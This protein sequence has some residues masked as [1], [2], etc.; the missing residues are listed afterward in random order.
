MF[1]KYQREATHIEHNERRIVRRA[2]E[3]LFI[4]CLFLNCCAVFSANLSGAAVV[5]LTATRSTGPVKENTDFSY[6]FPGFDK[7]A[8][9]VGDESLGELNIVT[10]DKSGLLW[11]GTDVTGLVRY[12]GY[13]WRSYRHIQG[14]NKSLGSN[15]VLAL[16]VAQDGLIWVGTSQ[17]VSAFDPD[18]EQSVNYVHDDANPDSLVGDRVNRILGDTNGNIWLGVFGKGLDYLAKGSTTIRHFHHDPA[19]PTSLANDFVG[20]LLIDRQ[21]RFWVGTRDGLQRLLPDGTGFERVASRSGD[22]NSLAGKS[23][24]SLYEALDGKIWIGT[25]TGLAWMDPATFELHFIGRDNAPG[26]RL[27]NEFI[28]KIIQPLPDEIW[29]ATNGG[30][31]DVLA[32]DDGRVLQ[33]WQKDSSLDGNLEHE[34]VL[35]MAR[36]NEGNVWVSGMQEFLQRYNL[37]QRF[38]Y[39]IRH[40][41]ERINGLSAKSATSVLELPDGR[42]LVGTDGN[43]IDILDRQ[44]G[45]VGGYRPDGRPGSLPKGL[46]YSLARSSDGT[47]WAGTYT[48]VW[49]LPPGQA[50]WNAYTDKGI[51]K[52]GIVQQFYIDSDDSVW[53]STLTGLL[54]WTKKANRFEPVL[55]DS[56]KPLELPASASIRDREGNLWVGMNMGLGVIEPGHT[57]VRMVTK[58]EQ[59]NELCSQRVN[60]FLIDHEGHLLII[61]LAGVDKLLKWDGKTATIE[62]V[63]PGGKCNGAV[64]MSMAEDRQGR[65]WSENFVSS[66]DHAAVVLENTG[67]QTGMAN[68]EALA[69]TRDGLLLMGRQNGLLIVDPD[70][71]RWQDD[72]PQVVVTDLRIDGQKSPISHLSPSIKL[73]PDQRNFTLDFVALN[74]AGNKLNSY[75]YQLEGFS[76]DWS[77]TDSH[78]RFVVF[79]NLWPGQYRLHV[80]SMNEAGV[81]DDKDGLSIPVTVLPAFWQ[82]VWFAVLMV[83]F[84]IAFVAWLVHM[85]TVQL[86]R[87]QVELESIVAKRT[88]QLKESNEALVIAKETAERATNSKSEFLANMSHEIRTPMNAIIGMANL[89]LRTELSERQRDY[90]QKVQ[91]S[92]KH[93]LRIINDVLDLS[94][95]EAGKLELENN[96]FNLEQMLN[97]AMTLTI[98]RASDKGLQLLIDVAGNVPQQLMGDETRLSQMLVNY[99]S[100]AIK[101]TDKG[102][103]TLVVRLKEKT[104]EGVLVYFAVKDTGIGLNDDQQKRLFQQFQQANSSTTRL[105]GGTGLGLALVKTLAGQMQG[106]VGV[107]S[108]VGQGSTF[109][110]TVQLGVVE[111]SEPTARPFVDARHSEAQAPRQDLAGGRVLL[112]EDNLLNQQVA[113]ELMSDAGLIVTVASDGE[114]AQRLARENE[115]ELILM[116]M[117]MPVMD[118][119]EATRRIRADPQ[120]RGT[121]VIAMTANSLQVDRQHC[122]DAGMVDF[123]TK[124]IDPAE[125]FE[126]LRKWVQ[127]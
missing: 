44:R 67:F 4:F 112:V 91:Q 22:P 125:L 120:Y 34:I 76:K 25:K 55:L 54:R 49:A 47:L 121:P 48:G 100:N 92:G 12:D 63:G 3:F 86:K 15:S 84:A 46:I 10:V 30:G 73:N 83:L 75:R 38:G 110:F 9:G 37:R 114:A 78:H 51:D 21:G 98:D 89:A 113:S 81:W 42:I 79:G 5:D 24:V 60:N 101:F 90:L 8:P 68:S 119:L 27:T 122:L 61:S 41:T 19:S 94:K 7:L 106:D 87:R 36:D 14:D 116:D 26:N 103:V 20:G 56:G 72:Q 45:L 35:G 39:Q 66:Y 104:G 13:T 1:V 117:Q 23:I 80:R 71:Y 18:T 88:S 109:W 29:A 102:T 69:K 111:P 93:L 59:T 124:P 96:P 65:L 85:R 52:M 127:K 123:I 57:T 32:A 28:T 31:I 2:H 33:R 70:K 82:T 64:D 50:K 16:W 95:V 40:S 11:I 108:T 74:Y 97:K 43:G 58:A 17:G 77:E 115:Y 6:A 107:E 118:G 53:A 62:H 126:K 99:L 105:Y